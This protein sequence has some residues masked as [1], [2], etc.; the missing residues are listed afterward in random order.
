MIRY[1]DIKAVCEKLGGNRPLH[2][3]T[4]HRAVQAGTLP[5]P[6]KLGRIARWREDEVDEVLQRLADARE[7]SG[8]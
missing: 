7:R 1:L 6:I 3:A 4:I 8:A 2:P 5:A